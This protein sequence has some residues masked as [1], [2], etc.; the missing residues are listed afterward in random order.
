VEEFVSKPNLR[1]LI[2]IPFVDKGRDP[3]IGLDCWG[4]VIAVCERLGIKD[5][6]NYDVSCYD[7]AR[8]GAMFSV[9]VRKWKKTCTPSLGDFVVMELDPSMP[10]MRQHYG[11]YLWDG[12]FIHSLEKQ[13][14]RTDEVY[15]KFWKG[16]IKGYYTWTGIKESF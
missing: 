13:G 11:I 3:R 4:L 2:N 15:D 7:S 6:P 16:R 10:K 8:I 5:V 1:D 12:M 9:E 14:S